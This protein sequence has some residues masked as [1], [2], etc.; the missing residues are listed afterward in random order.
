MLKIILLLVILYFVFW[1]FFR[2]WLKP[3]VEVM[4]TFKTM[5]AEDQNKYTGSLVKGI[6]FVICISLPIFVLA[7]LALGYILLYVPDLRWAA[8]S[9]IAL[10][11]IHS[12]MNKQV[13][14]LMQ[15]SYYE[16]YSTIQSYVVQFAY[17]VLF[18]YMAIRL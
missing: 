2:K 10:Y 6:L 14:K 18:T 11:F 13:K 15:S 8:A 5:S 9:V 3:K 17:L 16:K 4:K 1:F 12:I 7:V